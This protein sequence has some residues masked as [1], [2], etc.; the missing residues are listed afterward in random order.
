MSV[1]K[2]GEHSPIVVGLFCPGEEDK[3]PLTIITESWNCRGWKGPLRD[4]RPSCQSRLPIAGAQVGI[5]IVL[6][7]LQRMRI[8]SLPGQPDGASTPSL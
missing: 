7:Y 4:H 3:L 8:H 5:Q 2:A 6:G 1:R